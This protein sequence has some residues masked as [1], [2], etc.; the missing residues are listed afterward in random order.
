MYLAKVV[1]HFECHNLIIEARVKNGHK[2]I[3]LAYRHSAETPDSQHWVLAYN[4]LEYAE[5][6]LFEFDNYP[7]PIFKEI[8]DGVEIIN[9][10]ERFKLASCSST[11]PEW[12]NMSG[13][14]FLQKCFALALFYENIL[15]NNS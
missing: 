4:N 15:I 11:A 5:Y 2:S 8:T 10:A 13:S 6:Y 1:R 12:I 9:F 7:A 14:P 3:F